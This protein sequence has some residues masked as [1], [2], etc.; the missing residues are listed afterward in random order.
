VILEALVDWLHAKD[1]AAAKSWLA[2]VAEESRNASQLP[3]QLT[4]DNTE[5]KAF[6][7]GLLAFLRDPER[8]YHK[9][10]ERLLKSMFE[11]DFKTAQRDAKKRRKIV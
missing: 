4:P 9:E 5:E 7:A 8:P 1:P 6:V 3:R 2:K 10:M 11:L